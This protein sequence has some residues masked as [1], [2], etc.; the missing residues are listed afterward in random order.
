VVLEGR[1]VTIDYGGL[2]AVD[3][4]DFELHQGEIV[5]LL[6]PNGSGKTSLF[7]TICGITSLSEGNILVQDKFVTSQSPW[8]INHAG[9]ARTFQRIRIY[10]KQTVYD[11]MLLARRWKGVPPW[12]WVFT[13]PREVRE[14]ADDLIHFL[15]IG[16]VRHNLANNL[17]GGQQR[18]LEIGMT[19][20]CDPVVVLLDEATS[21]VN[22]ALVKEIKDSI[23]RANRERGITF[24]LVEHNMSFAMELCSRIYVLD[25]GVK[26]AE[27]DPESIQNNAQVIEAYF[28]HD[29]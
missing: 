12:L 14:K 10:K 24:F 2:R 26:I 23:R 18:L 29:H 3:H 7:N 25:H 1:G 4:V 6:G 28:G 16:H 19:L 8:Q 15:K 11:N 27:G 17:S 20:M 22:P 21:G 13:A 9:L 5:G